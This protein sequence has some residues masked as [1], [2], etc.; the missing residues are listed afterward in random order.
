VSAFLL[1]SLIIAIALLVATWF[2]GE[3]ICRRITLRYERRRR[4]LWDGIGP[5]DRPGRD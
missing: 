2:A 1:V 4:R 3:W 5:E